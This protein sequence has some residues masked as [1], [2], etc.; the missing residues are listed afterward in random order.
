MDKKEKFIRKLDPK[1]RKQVFKTIEKILSRQWEHLDI[2]KLK[3][4]E[5]AYRIRKGEIRIVFIDK[6]YDIEVLSIGYRDEDTYK[7]F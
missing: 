4:Y 3:G 5:N 6:G 7:N 1:R 2:R